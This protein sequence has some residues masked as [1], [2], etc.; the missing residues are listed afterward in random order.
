MKNKWLNLVLLLTNRIYNRKQQI[1]GQVGLVAVYNIFLLIVWEIALGVISLPLYL[2]LKSEVVTAYMAERGGY[3]KVAFDYNLRRILTVTGVG[4][5]ALIWAIKLA[6]ILLLP[7]VYGPLQLYYVSGFGPADILSKDLVAAET[8][9]QTARVVGTIA[10]PELTTVKKVQGG[11]Y[12][13]YGKGQPNLAVVL[14]LSDA[15][16]AIYSADTDKN[17]DWQISHLQSNFKLSE[18]NHSVIIFSYDK[19]QGIRSDTAPEQFFKVKTSWL[20]QFTKNVD[21]L[22]N[23]SVVIV[24]V[25]GIFLTFL[26]I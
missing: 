3:G 15:Q 22:A 16:T 18:G 21:V 8:G 19:Q 12:I 23:W 10:K 20:D 11:N 25:L 9:I 5:V 17:G 1:I 24:I 13:F 4:I 14:L 2:T 26:T 6:L 7:T